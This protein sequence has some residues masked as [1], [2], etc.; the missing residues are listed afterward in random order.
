MVVVEGVLE[1]LMAVGV[2]LFLRLSVRLYYL[3]IIYRVFF[4]MAFE[5]KANY[6]CVVFLFICLF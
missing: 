3:Q 4:L 5:N 6:L 2:L 1:V